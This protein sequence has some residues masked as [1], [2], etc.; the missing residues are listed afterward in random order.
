[1]NALYHHT[2]WSV[3]IADQMLL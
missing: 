3:G 2:K 1:M